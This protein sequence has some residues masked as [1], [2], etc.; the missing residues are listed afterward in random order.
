MALVGIRKEVTIK[1]EKMKSR[2]ICDPK[3]GIFFSL[4]LIITRSLKINIRTG[5]FVGMVYFLMSMLININLLAEIKNNYPPLNNLDTTY[6]SSFQGNINIYENL[7][8]N[9]EDPNGLTFNVPFCTDDF[10][11]LE[12][13]KEFFISDFPEDTFLLYMGGISWTSEIFIN[14]K[15]ITLTDDPF[16]TYFI[17]I[18]PTVLRNQW[19]KLK[20]RLLK[21]GPT[22]SFLPAK[23]IGIH[24]PIY[25]FKGTSTE[26]VRKFSFPN[27]L[28]TPYTLIYAPY[29]EKY[30]YNIDVRQAEADFIKIKQKNVTSIYFPFNPSLEILSLVKKCG[31]SIQTEITNLQAVYRYYPL[32]QGKLQ[33]NHLWINKDEE[34]TELYGKFRKVEIENEKNKIQFDKTPV[35]IFLFIPIILITVWKLLNERTY[36]LMLSLVNFKINYSEIIKGSTNISLSVVYFALSIRILLWASMITVLLERMRVENNL[37]YLNLVSKKSILYEGVSMLGSDI[38]LVYLLVLLILVIIYIIK[39]FLLSFVSFVYNI[40]DLLTRIVNTEH[41]TEFPFNILITIL[42][43]LLIVALKSEDHVIWSILGILFIVFNTRKY[44]LLFEG[45]KSLL[46]IPILINVLYICGVE[47]LPWILIL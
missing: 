42:V 10:D 27:I 47:C 14:E 4:K 7:N 37:K 21:N 34:Q 5:I 8:G 35:I 11:Q 6:F 40:P 45:L 41:K 1:K 24:K 19:N 20:I 39:F 31:L 44:Y 29:S 9:W 16:K 2:K 33:K 43:T 30:G 28:N 18:P 12:L 32:S 23:M 26:L 36:K 25:L 3:E 38:L 17:K 46:K 22:G 13:K 15:L